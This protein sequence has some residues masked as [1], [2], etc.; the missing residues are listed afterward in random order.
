MVGTISSVVPTRAVFAAFGAS[1]TAERMAG[2]RGP[3]WRSGHIV[4]RPTGDP[5]KA[6]WK[7]QVLAEIDSSE[8]FTVP[9]PIV[10]D[11][12]NWVHDGWQAIEWIPGV[13][14][15]LESATF[16]VQGM[17]SIEQLRGSGARP[18]SRRRTIRGARLI[19]LHGL[20]RPRL[21]MSFSNCSWR[22]IARSTHRRRLS[23]AIIS[24][25]SC[26]Q[27]GARWQ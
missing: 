18:L 5:E 25:T 9:R 2:G 11:R 20:R 21:L 24:G 13:R 26:S 22:R 16:C 27:K 7:S 23:T 17:R 10:D 4:V 14:T 6:I 15:R 1:E 12:G 3:T 8:G 19:G